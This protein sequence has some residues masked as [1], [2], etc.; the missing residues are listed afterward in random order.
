MSEA[1]YSDRARL[2]KLSSLTLGCLATRDD[3]GVVDATWSGQRSYRLGYGLTWSTDA[4]SGYPALLTNDKVEHFFR[5]AVPEAGLK[6][7]DLI[8]DLYRKTTRC[9]CWRQFTCQLFKRVIAR[10][11]QCRK[12]FEGCPC[13]YLRTSALRPSNWR[14]RGRRFCRLFCWR[15]S[16][17]V[18]CEKT[19]R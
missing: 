1:R 5:N 16:E 9:A 19:C 3:T 13:V 12:V 11:L 4:A 15:L 8:N 2:S 6:S 10:F 14:R 7:V 17:S 18:Y